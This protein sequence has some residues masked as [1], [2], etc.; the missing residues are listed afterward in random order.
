MAESAKLF[1]LRVFGNTNN[2]DLNINASAV[3]SVIRGMF[4]DSDGLVVILVYFF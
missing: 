1:F 3:L 2:P 4:V